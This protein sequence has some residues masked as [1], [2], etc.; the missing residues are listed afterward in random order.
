MRLD[1]SRGLIGEGVTGSGRLVAPIAACRCDGCRSGETGDDAGHA[2]APLVGL[3]AT[4]K[5]TGRWAP[6]CKKSTPAATNGSAT[7]TRTRELSVAE[8]RYRAAHQTQFGHSNRLNRPFFDVLVDNQGGSGG[9]FPPHPGQIGQRLRNH[10]PGIIT[11]VRQPLAVGV[12]HA[13]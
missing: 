1:F 2:Q 4:V 11:E 6:S 12:E 8:Q 5:S 3:K 7:S 9:H 13:H 10:H